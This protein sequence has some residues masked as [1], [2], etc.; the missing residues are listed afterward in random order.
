MDD[1]L[2][3]RQFAS[4]AAAAAAGLALGKIATPQDAAKPVVVSDQDAAT[5]E[6]GL[7]APLSDEAKSI[8]KSTLKANRE[9]V[10]AR[11]KFKLPENSEPCTVYMPT[12][13]GKK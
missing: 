1:K 5:I 9:G 4:R 8:L 7:S 13:G 12:S 3:R 10:E 2:S 11:M 6:A